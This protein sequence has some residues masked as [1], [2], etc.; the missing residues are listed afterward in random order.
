MEECTAIFANGNVTNNTTTITNT[1]TN[2]SAVFEYIDYILVT[3]VILIICVIGIIGNVLNLVV[4]TKKTFKKNMDRMEKLAHMGLIALAISDLLFCVSALP[5][6][7]KDERFEYRSLSFW[8]LYNMYGEAVINI[9]IMSSTWL[10]V[11]MALSRF[12]AICYPLHGRRLLGMTFGWLSVVLVFIF[13]V[14]F[15]LPRFWMKQIASVECIEG[16][17]S[18]FPVLGPMN[19]NRNAKLAY[20]WLYFI[21]CILVPLLILTYCNVYLVRAL[22]RSARMRKEHTRSHM[23]SGDSTNIVTLTLTVIVVFYILLVVPAELLNFGKL[24]VISNNMFSIPRGYNL[25]ISFC[26]ALQALNFAFN[27]VLY[28]VINVHFR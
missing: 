11:A 7:F 24:S 8:L 12:I 26:N 4:L 10:T 27:F 21:V 1:T 19:L 2:S 20:M 13:C 18:Y 23:S 25:A 17:M 3:K 22:H 28:C 15:N 5:H 16:G 14:L 9:F 6:S